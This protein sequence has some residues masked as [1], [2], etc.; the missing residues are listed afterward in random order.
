[1]LFIFSDLTFDQQ[2]FPMDFISARMN[3][4][5]NTGNSELDQMLSYLLSEPGKML[6]PR[7][8][9][10][11]SSLYPSDQNVV[12]DGA[13][14]LELIHLASL[15]HDDVVD[16]SLLRRGKA[17]VYQ[18][19]G[20]K[21]SVL[22]GDYLF[23]TA[24]R[25][26]N[27]HNIP[28]ILDTVTR[29]IQIMCSG[30]IEQ[31][32][33]SFAVG[34]VLSDYLER[35]YRKTACLFECCC[36]VGALATSMPAQQRDDLQRYGVSMGMAYQIIDDVLDFL[37]TPEYLGK[38]SGSDLL[39][40]NITLPVIYGLQDDHCGKEIAALLA[41]PAY[42]EAQLDRIKELLQQCGAFAKSMQL[43]ES[44]LADARASLRIIPEPGRQAL[45]SLSY[46]LSSHY[47]N[48]MAPSYSQE[49]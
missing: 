43:A 8:V 16:G 12:Q 21:A 7:L 14:A 33:S 22:L 1:V 45:S 35:I 48:K 30:E 4:I 13:V 38:P 34:L 40:G 31:L 44:Y 18:R 41:Q 39:E 11:A 10:L 28:A 2:P 15:V 6:R 36:R 47:F 25:L 5:L 3:N 49:S 19:W 27:Q 32:S 20:S 46:A 23:A 26:I 29:T 42:L 9:F 37:S 24:F 17:S